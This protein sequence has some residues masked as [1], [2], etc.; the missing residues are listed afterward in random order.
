MEMIYDRADP[1]GVESRTHYRSRVCDETAE[2]AQGVSRG[3]MQCFLFFLRKRIYTNVLLC[4]YTDNIF[5]PFLSSQKLFI[6]GGSF[7][8][9]ISHLHA[10][11]CK[12]IKKWILLKS[13]PVV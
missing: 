4:N 8:S 3:T 10:I 5:N 9:V 11:L 7:Y 6:C 12:L 13:K 2:S 1:D